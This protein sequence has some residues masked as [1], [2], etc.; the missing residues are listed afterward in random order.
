LQQHI[1]SELQR[2]AKEN[3]T[4]I[5]AGSFN[6]AI[7]EEKAPTK[8]VMKGQRNTLLHINPEGKII[9]VKRKSQAPE[10]SFVIK[11]GS[12]EYKVLPLICA[13]I[14][15]NYELDSPGIYDAEKSRLTGQN[16]YHEIIPEWIKQG[17]PYDIMIHP[18]RLGD[19]NFNTLA[20]YT[21]NSQMPKGNSF[22][23]PEKTL[24]WLQ[25]AYDEYYDPYSPFLKDK[26]PIVTADLGIASVFKKGQKPL[27]RYSATTTYTRAESR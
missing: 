25:T 10:G 16:V 24:K 5:F 8:Y 12:N 2:L 22:E 27:E 3:Q 1:L 7:D 19:V 17:A 9:G 14:D 6:E 4:T 15:F 23:T 26:A 13:E 20:E 21:Q 11:K 18:Q